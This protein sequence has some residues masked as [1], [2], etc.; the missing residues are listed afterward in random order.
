MYLLDLTLE[1]RI[2]CDVMWSLID[3]KHNVSVP[4]HDRLLVDSV[5]YGLDEEIDGM[6][7]TLQCSWTG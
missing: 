3:G 1:A 5:D 2:H 7:L 6:L 4:H